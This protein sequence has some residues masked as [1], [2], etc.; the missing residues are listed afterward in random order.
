MHIILPFLKMTVQEEVDP[1]LY[2][3]FIPSSTQ[4]VLFIEDYINKKYNIPGLIR[5]RFLSL[6]VC[7][8]VHECA[9]SK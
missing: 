1:P 5:L 8:H 9:N 6:Y 7:I 2:L 3:F 4:Q